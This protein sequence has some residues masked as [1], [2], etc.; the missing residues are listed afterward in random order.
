MSQGLFS[1]PNNSDNERYNCVAIIWQLSLQPG[2]CIEGGF[3]EKR[4]LTNNTI[5]RHMQL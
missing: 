5:A 3:P 1:D 4:F 2:E